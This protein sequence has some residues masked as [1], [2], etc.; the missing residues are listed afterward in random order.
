MVT[1]FQ[2]LGHTAYSLSGTYAFNI[3]FDYS[4]YDVVYI[5]NDG[6]STAEQD[7]LVANCES[8]NIE[9]LFGRE[10]D[11]GLISDMGASVSYTM[12]DPFSVI[13]NFHPIT[14]PFPTGDV[15]ILFDWRSYLNSPSANTTILANAG[16]NASIVVHN[17]YRKA[18]CPY[19]GH[20]SGMPWS[21]EGGVLVSRAIRWA[22]GKL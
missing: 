3:P 4:P 1:E 17:T 21:Y 9:L 15:D 7:D 5:C 16:S 11:V 6:L 10:V 8:G 2:G 19:Y 14:S 18:V 20:T 12:S 13:N 22:A